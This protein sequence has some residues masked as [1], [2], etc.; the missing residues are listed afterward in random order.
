MGSYYYLYD[1]KC[2]YCGQKL[3]EVIYFDNAC[4]KNGHE[5]GFDTGK[6]EHCGKEFRIDM[7]FVLG[8]YNR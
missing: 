5:Q 8:K 1:K 4:D 7:D 3:N 6:C 2:P